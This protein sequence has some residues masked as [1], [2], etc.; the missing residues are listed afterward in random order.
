MMVNKPFFGQWTQ[1]LNVQ[2]IFETM[3]SLLFPERYK[4]LRMLCVDNDCSSILELLDKMIDDQTHEADI[5]A[6]REEFEDAD[7]SD[8]GIK[9]QS[10]PYKRHHQMTMDIFEQHEAQYQSREE[11]ERQAEE[12]RQWLEENMGF[13]PFDQEW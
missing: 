10:S 7:R 13:K 8:W 11:I 9:P 6:M 12:A 2:D 1:T 3:I 5:K 4:R